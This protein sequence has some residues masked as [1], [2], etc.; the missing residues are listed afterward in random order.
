MKILIA[1]LL[2][3]NI[4]VCDDDYSHHFPKDLSFL[5][6]SKDQKNS[7]KKLLKSHQKKMQ[8]LYSIRENTMYNIK[9]SFISQNFNTNDYIKKSMKIKQLSSKLEADFFTK[10]HTI[11][12][13]EQRKKF[14]VYFGEW[15]IE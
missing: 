2:S 6:L 15:E 5:D 14:V 10:L 8:K 4:L 12:D 3:F 11:L 1:I 13:K 9:M 7:I